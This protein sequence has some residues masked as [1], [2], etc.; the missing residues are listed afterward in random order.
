MLVRPKKNVLKT[1][2]RP[3]EK[4]PS[5]TAGKTAGKTAQQDCRKDCVQY[6]RRGRLQLQPPVKRHV[7]PGFS[8][9][10]AGAVFQELMKRALAFKRGNSNFSTDQADKPR[11]KPP[12]STVLQAFFRK[13][14]QSCRFR[15]QMLRPS[16]GP[17]GA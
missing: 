15:T 9:G 10:L 17:A 2:E 1:A 8:R 14:F 13:L 5:K 3:P 12:S 16:E 7:E 4:P 6:R 11:L